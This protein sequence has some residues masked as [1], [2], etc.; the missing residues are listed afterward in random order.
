MER[1]MDMEERGELYSDDHA[2]FLMQRAKE[3]KTVGEF[4]RRLS[5][6][7]SDA[8]MR[9]TVLLNDEEICEVYD[10]W[11]SDETNTYYVVLKTKGKI[12]G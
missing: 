1:D 2:L 12:H 7:P 11:Y 3:D 10:R 6:A 4:Q 8:E 9:F 5:Q